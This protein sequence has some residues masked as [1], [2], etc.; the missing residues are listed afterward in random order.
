MPS[1]FARLA[2]RQGYWPLPIFNFRRQ[3]RPQRAAAAKASYRRKENFDS[4]DERRS[5]P[6]MKTSRVVS[7]LIG[8][9]VAA[10][11]ISTGWAQRPAAAPAA[12]IALVN[13]VELSQKSTRIQQGIEKLKQ[14]YMANGEALKKE[15]ERGN[16]LTEQMRKMPPGPEKKKAE[17][18]LAKMRADYELKG[19]KL[20]EEASDRESNLYFALAKEVQEELARYSTATG[21]P[22]V[23]RYEPSPPELIERQSIAMEIQKL[24]I[25]SRDPDI[26]PQLSE[27]IN[28]RPAASGATR[29]AA[30]TRGSQ[31]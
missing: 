10:M 3:C 1:W 26:T 13:V 22:L 20:T 23:L 2:F 4:P 12:K 18:D 21:V 8:M 15:G 24:V 28:R 17:Q 7:A 29:P 14:E 31:R 6:G 5:K 25:Y 9:G 19:K 11:T 27:A 30:T 16:A